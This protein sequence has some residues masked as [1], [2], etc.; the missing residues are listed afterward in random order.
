MHS[1][2]STSCKQYLIVNAETN[3]EMLKAKGIKRNMQKKC[4]G[5]QDFVHA[6]KNGGVSKSIMQYSLKRTHNAIYLVGSKKR[7]LS[8]FTTKRLFS[9]KFFRKDCAFGF[10]LHLKS[11]IDSWFSFHSFKAVSFSF[12]FL[13]SCMFQAISFF[14][15]YSPL[16]QSSLQRYHFKSA[17]WQRILQSNV[18]RRTLNN[19]KDI[20]IGILLIVMPIKN[21]WDCS[22]TGI[23]L[24]IHNTD[25]HTNGRA[26][27]RMSILTDE[28]TEDKH[29]EP[30]R[31]TTDER[32]DG[33]SYKQ[34][35][36]STT[37]DKQ[38][39]KLI[40]PSC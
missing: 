40:K 31:Q 9:K 35:T 26:Y 12:T 38:T 13:S 4:V 36:N 30:T 29:T 14:P 6:T 20:F 27:R 21:R 10:P 32:T 1:F 33:Q 24:S 2:F 15:T 34:H 7:V 17:T 5:Y 22:L 19:V 25:E 16:S 37:T 8:C 18:S 28:H 23:C 11:S 39:D 3:T